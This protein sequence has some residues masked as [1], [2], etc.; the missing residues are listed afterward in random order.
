M[1]SLRRSLA[2]VFVKPSYFLVAFIA[3]SGVL[4]FSIWLPNLSLVKNTLFSS[5]LSPAQKAAL[6]I[7]TLGGFETNFTP[8]SRL[9]TLSVAVLFGV[10]F[11]MLVY[12]MRNKVKLEK[13]LGLGFGGILTGLVGV[14]CASCGSVILSSIFGIGATAGFLAFLPFKGQ[15]F[16]ILSIAILSISIYKI[17]Q[18]IQN[19]IL[20]R[21]DSSLTK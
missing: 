2:Q 14:G 7:A 13:S 18:K 15:E 3:A 1:S 9:L 17:S 12:Y 16:G 11:A 5:Y 10:N 6:L 20:C 19:P 8:L 4:V 21:K